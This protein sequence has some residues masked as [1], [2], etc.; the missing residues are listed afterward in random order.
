MLWHFWLITSCLLLL[1][2]WLTYSSKMSIRGLWEIWRSAYEISRICHKYGFVVLNWLLTI[3]AASIKQ[4]FNRQIFDK[5]A[6]IVCIAKS[7]ITFFLTV[8]CVSNH[9]N[10]W[11][12]VP[13]RKNCDFIFICSEVTAQTTRSVSILF[14]SIAS[15]HLTR[16]KNVMVSDFL[17]P[18]AFRWYMTWM[19]LQR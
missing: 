15:R 1:K 5:C 13:K 16:R 2:T 12:Q 18:R 4:F 6:K 7:M 3:I 8:D 9:I 19:I 14:W 17:E 11:H 10:E